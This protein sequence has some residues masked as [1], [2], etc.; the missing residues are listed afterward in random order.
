M[1]VRDTELGCPEPGRKTG[2][3]RAILR[4]LLIV[5]GAAAVS[6]VAVGCV[7]YNLFYNAKRSFGEAERSPRAPDGSITS[8]IAADYDKVIEKCQQ[9]ITEHPKSKYVDDAILLM[10]K[11]QYAKGEYD[12]AAVTFQDLENNFPNSDL[13]VQGQLYLAKCQLELDDP[14]SAASILQTLYDN[15]KGGKYGDELLYT[16]GTALIRVGDE[17]TATKYLQQL[18][19]HYPNSPFRLEAD[20]EMAGLYTDRG[21]YDKALEIYTKL[22]NARVPE[23]DKIRY[24]SRLSKLYVLM[25]KYQ[26]ALKVIDELEGDVLDAQLMAE[27]M[28]LQGEAYTGIDNIDKAI[29][30]YESVTARF[31]RSKFAAEAFF[32][33]GD[34]YQNKLDSLNT[35]KKNY[36][37]VPRQYANSPFAGDAVSRSVAITKLERLQASLAEGSTEGKANVQFE[38]AE[39]QLLQ[40]NNGDKALG[41]YQSVLADYPQSE[42][43]PKAAYAI[44][45]I[46]DKVFNDPANARVAYQRLLRDYPDSQQAEYVRAYLNSKEGKVLEQS[47]SDS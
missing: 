33:L 14:A 16:L 12:Q 28:L 26:D 24:M 27:Q 9:L 34:V 23:K 18:A 42:V 19:A 32:R 3:R 10:G 15:K 7:Y 13:N 35:A 36:D 5:V 40:F 17:E 22:T 46:Y 6:Q 31:P 39:T 2:R 11:S 44:A 30:T 47:R 43:A 45:Y 37:E 38:L 29:D 20:L 41:L 25:G 4:A 1:T 8:N 21:D